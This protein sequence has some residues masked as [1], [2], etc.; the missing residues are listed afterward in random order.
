MK[1]PMVAT[2]DNTP[3]TLT[4][5]SSGGSKR[6]GV[7]SSSSGASRKKG[8]VDVDQ[9]VTKLLGEEEQDFHSLRVREVTA[10]EREANA[11]MLE[12]EAISAKANKETALLAIDEKVK[13][14]RAR[15]QLLEE[16]ISL[17]QIDELLPLPA[18]HE[19]K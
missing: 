12:A 13:L 15:K 3:S 8:K 14:L 19:K 7:S 18:N 10:R 5:R 1:L 2:E 16:G 9:L 6:L 11:S 4:T 17:K